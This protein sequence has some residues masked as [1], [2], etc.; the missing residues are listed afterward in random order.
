M[1]NFAMTDRTGKPSGN[2][3]QRPGDS[4]AKIEIEGYKTIDPADLEDL[5]DI[6]GFGPEDRENLV[7]LIPD[8][9][10]ELANLSIIKP[11]DGEASE[12]PEAI[13]RSILAKLAKDDP[14][15]LDRIVIKFDEDDEC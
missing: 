5:P 3:K 8:P 7:E 1:R 6:P 4:E 9:E 14:T 13:V 2:K 12:D 15:V 10:G 11:A